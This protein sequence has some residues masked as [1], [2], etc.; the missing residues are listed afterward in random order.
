MAVS[1]DFDKEIHLESVHHIYSP[2]LHRKSPHLPSFDDYGAIV[3]GEVSHLEPNG[4][5]PSRTGIFAGT[6]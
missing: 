3:R 2:P 6:S 1:M 4:H 5:L